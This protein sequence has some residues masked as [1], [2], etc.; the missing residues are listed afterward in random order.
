MASEPPFTDLPEGANVGSSGETRSQSR[1]STSFGSPGADSTVKRVDLNDAL[2]R[3]PQSTFV[4]RAKGSAMHDAGI[5]DGDVLLV[6]RSLKATSGNIVIVS[7]DGELLCRR[8]SIGPQAVQLLAADGST[9]P[10]VLPAGEALEVWGVVTTAI[11]S[12][13]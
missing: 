1:R 10:R 2:I 5:G 6:D 9:P 3:R 13:L 7:L 12:L 11:K 8:L 4:F